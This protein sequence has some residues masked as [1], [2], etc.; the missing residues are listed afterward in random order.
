[1]YDTILSIIL[2]LK[3]RIFRVN[4]LNMG[5]IVYIEITDRKEGNIWW[6]YGKL[7]A[8]IYYIILLCLAM[9]YVH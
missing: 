8:D 9:S 4:C 1:M 7:F 5:M 6:Y 3:G 2:S